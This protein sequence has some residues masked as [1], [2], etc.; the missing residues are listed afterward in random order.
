[1]R[2]NFIP[3]ARVAAAGAALALALAAGCSGSG[4]DSPVAPA[5]SDALNSPAAAPA[6]APGDIAQGSALTGERI[7]SDVPADPNPV[8]PDNTLPGDQPQSVDP[9]GLSGT[10]PMGAYRL[11]INKETMEADLEPL[12]RTSQISE[13]FEVDVTEFFRR[14]PC[15]DCLQIVG[16]GLDGQGRVLADVQMRHPFDVPAPGTG[17]LDL[18]VFDMTLSLFLTGNSGDP[19]FTDFGDIDVRPQPSTMDSLQLRDPGFLANADGFSA[20]LDAVYEGIIPTG[21]TAHPFKVMRIEDPVPGSYDPG[22]VSGFS[23][24]FAPEGYNV[25]PMG[26]AVEEQFV[27]DLGAQ[28]QAEIFLVLDAKY[29]VSAM[30]N[31]ATGNPGSRQNP[32][33][34]LPGFNRREAWRVGVSVTSNNLMDNDPGSMASIEVQV[35]DWQQSLGTV[36]PGF[37]PLTA[38]LDSLT[39]SSLVSELVLA[40]PGVFPGTLT[41]SVA[42]GGTGTVA[43]PLIYNF[44]FPRFQQSHRRHLLGCRGSPR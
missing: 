18:H 14:N 19:G 43:D 36:A 38:S 16:L 6:P 27:L 12:F 33:Y 44:S 25:F 31:I 17:R 22:T 4:G 5:P 39:D 11:F 2:S 29:G 40:V 3:G 35:N 23:D 37:D 10:A 20:H 8:S 32:R 34:F 42:A 24:L 1:M 15:G 9:D 21:A 41:E 28:Q 30:A 13:D 26:S 7:I